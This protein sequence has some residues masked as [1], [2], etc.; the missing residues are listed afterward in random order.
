MIVRR[1]IAALIAVLIA[2]QVVRNAAVLAFAERKPATAAQ[3]WPAHPSTEL[4]L[5]M[6]QIARA[7]RDRRSVPASAF[8]LMADAAAKEPLAP[9]PYLVRGVQ[10]Q[11]A[12]DGR[13][14]QRAFEAAQWRDPRS[15]PAAY[16]LADRYFRAGDAERGL[17]QVAALVRLAPNGAAA[18]G[19]YLAAYAANSANWPALRSLFRANPDLAE[20]T[21]VTL[22]SNIAT[23]PAVFALADP[24]EKA[25]DAQW[26]APLLNTLIFSGQYAEARAIWAKAI[27]LQAGSGQLLYDSSFS[28]RTSPP[29]FNWALNS[30]TV[31]L[32]ERQPGGRLHIVFYGQE[33]GFLASQLLLLQPGAYRLSLQ[34][35]GDPARA[36][37]LNWSVW[38]DKAIEPLASVTLDAAAARGWRFEVPAGCKA[39]WLKLS[40]TSGDMPQQSDV[41]IATLKLEKAGSG[42]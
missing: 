19:P 35:F 24:H 28:D 23:V 32:T 26:L 30:S 15:L 9:E 4:S 16:F 5:A 34:L 37:M 31:G 14:A 25:T 18:V 11:L 2:V 17:R 21:L 38:C 6:M 42:A 27:G 39:Q 41:T 22:A 13:T 20:R 33:D 40:G 29:P 10:A 7:A 8:S 12:G 1:I 36:H 3:F